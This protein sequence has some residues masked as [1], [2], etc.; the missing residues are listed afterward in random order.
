VSLPSE[1]PLP[2]DHCRHRAWHSRS[3]RAR[4]VKHPAARK[5]R[6]AR[7]SL[8]CQFERLNLLGKIEQQGVLVLISV[9]PWRAR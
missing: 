2:V 7:G 6:L 9:P 3:A 8:D 5:G 1:K 4:C